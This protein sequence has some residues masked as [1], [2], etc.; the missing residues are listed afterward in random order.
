MAYAVRF[1]N[2]TKRYPRGWTEGEEP[3]YAS[4]RHDVASVGRR[5][6]RRSSGPKG[7]GTLALDGVS[8]EVQGGESYALVGPNGAGKSTALKLI[9]RISYPTD[10]VVKIRGR[11]AALME[12]GAGVHPELTGR[13]NIWLYGQI[14]GFRK[15]DI[16]RRFDSIVD[17]AELAP[18][19]DTPVK[20]FSSGMQL[21]LGFAI[22]AHLEPDVFVVDEALAVGDAAFQMRCVDRMRELVA[23]GHTLLF[24]SHTLPVVREVCSRAILLRDG[25]VETDGPVE[26]VI[27]RYLADVGLS[28]RSQNR[29]PAEVIHVTAVRVA[30]PAQDRHVATGE[31]LTI[32]VSVECAEPL[33]DVV[34]GLGISD[35]RLGNLISASM[36][37]SGGATHLAAGHH[38]IEVQLRPIPLLTGTYE[39]WFSAA[40][41]SGTRYFAHPRPVGTLFIEPSHDGRKDHLFAVTGG[42]GPVAVPFRILVDGAEVAYS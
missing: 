7:R 28:Q 14:L 39:L 18:A 31:Q 32:M 37:S 25:K 3:R 41:A 5:L 24:V 1:E 21:R 11:V 38:D 17:F 6:A 9:S 29:S 12:V 19:I 33:D 35:G 36:L 8:F 15:V 42:F 13:E 20:F 34:L 23:E 4:L 27:N 26:D 30:G 40:A 16:E 2:V 22:A 10:G